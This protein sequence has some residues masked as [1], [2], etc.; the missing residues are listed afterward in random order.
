MDPTKRLRERQASER[1]KTPGLPPAKLALGCL[2]GIAI[3]FGSICSIAGDA[4]MVYDTWP[5]RNAVRTSAQ[6]TSYQFQPFG[7]APNMGYGRTSGDHR[8]RYQF[9]VDGQEVTGKHEAFSSDSTAIFIMEEFYLVGPDE[10]IPVYYA[11][12]DPQSHMLFINPVPLFRASAARLAW[13]S[14]IIVTG[15]LVVVLVV[16]FYRPKKAERYLPEK[17]G[18]PDSEIK[19]EDLK[20]KS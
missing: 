20:I 2:G 14:L 8:F 13:V 1:H 4:R 15:I 17:L 6:I 3:L 18:I 16:V 11:P 10:T 5:Y 9:T 12:G 7:N 19:I